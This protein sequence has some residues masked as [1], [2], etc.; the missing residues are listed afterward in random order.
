[1][2][3]I[4]KILDRHAINIYYICLIDAWCYQSIYFKFLYLHGF[5]SIS[6]FK[7]ICIVSATMNYQYLCITW[8]L[9][10]IFFYNDVY[11]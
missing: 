8:C 1:M 7:L 2:K 9:L 11:Y 3:D 6:F 5:I 4:Y 10:F